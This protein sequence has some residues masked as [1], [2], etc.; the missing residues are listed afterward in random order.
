MIL[1]LEVSA[2]FLTEI[3]W[4]DPRLLIYHLQ[5]DCLKKNGHFARSSEDLIGG[6]FQFQINI[7]ISCRTMIVFCP[8]P[9]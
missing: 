5:P 8:L 2:C 9:E 6:T 3:T 7:R 1:E 4:A